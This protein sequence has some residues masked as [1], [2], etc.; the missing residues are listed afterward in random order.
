MSYD[1]TIE[2][3]F[4]LQKHGIKLGLT[5]TQLLLKSMGDPHRAFR[6][7][8]VA[9]TNGKGSTSAFLSG[10]LASEGY[11]VG[12]YTS[13]H[14]VS[15]TER[16]RINGIPISEQRVV[17][18]AEKV[19]AK[20]A[21]IF[22]GREGAVS[23]TFFEVTT[24]MAFTY[25]AEEGVDV[26][27][28]EVGMGGRLDATNV[29]MPAVSVITNIELEHTEFLGSSIEQIAEEKAGIIK[30][31]VPVVTGATQP[32]VIAVFEKAAAQNSSPIYRMGKDFGPVRT[33]GSGTQ[34]FDYRGIS[35]DR[36]G[37]SL[38]LLGKH[39]IGNA[40]IAVAA[41]ECA[42]KAGIY[43]S[44]SAIRTGLSSARWAGR[45]ERVSE[46]PDIFL[47]GAHNPASAEILAEALKELKQNYRR[48]ILVVGILK[49]KDYRGI[50]NRLAPIADY[51]VATRPDYA[52]A[53]DASILAVEAGRIHR[54]VFAAETIGD[55]VA[56][57]R[58]KAAADDI[59]VITGSLYTVGDA[60]ALLVSP[61]DVP[62]RDLR[63]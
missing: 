28:I 22:A 24:V 54:N 7:F 17:E 29:I 47:D 26:A 53:M 1:R 20:H 14:L 63:G 42:V 15:F 6:S 37:L 44:E 3:L 58:R 33:A 9:G 13:P 18:L 61:A 46:R 48:L 49:D 34:K 43:V 45:L 35:A 31:K 8:H 10:V 30:P 56:L 32:E 59:I 55:A 12:L 4:G 40:C 60:R 36:A 5:T 25:F 16:I 41:L 27:V 38:S 19:R 50:L 23:P 52:R 11:R 2:Y 57:A 51:I 62:L 21:E 39:Q